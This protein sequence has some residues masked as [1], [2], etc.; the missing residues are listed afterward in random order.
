MDTYIQNGHST[1]LLDDEIDFS[2]PTNNLRILLLWQRIITSKMWKGIARPGGGEVSHFFPM[3]PAT[4][5][6]ILDLVEPTSLTKTPQKWIAKLDLDESIKLFGPLDDENLV[7]WRYRTYHASDS[8]N[9]ISFS[10]T[11]SKKS[12]PQ[13]IRLIYKPKTEI[14]TVNYWVVFIIGFNSKGKEIKD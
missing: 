3:T 10:T 6:F 12:V 7:G 5:N 4:F 8:F 14:L 1:W 2:S 9:K 13:F 11:I